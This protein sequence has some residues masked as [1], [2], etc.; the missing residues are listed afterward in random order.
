MQPQEET[1]RHTFQRRVTIT[2]L[3][4]MQQ[5]EGKGNNNNI[6]Q[7]MKNYLTILLVLIAIIMMASHPM[8]IHCLSSSSE[9]S[10]FMNS[11]NH[12]DVSMVE[13]SAQGNAALQSALD[14]LNYTSTFTYSGRITTLDLLNEVMKNSSLDRNTALDYINSYYVSI[15]LPV[16][17]QKLTNSNDLVERIE[18]LAVNRI[19]N[20]FY[21]MVNSYNVESYF[22]GKNTTVGKTVPL[23]TDLTSPYFPTAFDGKT[24]VMVF[25]PNGWANILKQSDSNAT[26]SRTILH[27]PQLKMFNPTTN[28]RNHFKIVNIMGKNASQVINVDSGKCLTFND[29]GYFNNL[30][31]DFQDCDSNN[32]NQLY[33]WTGTTLVPLFSRNGNQ[34]YALKRD[35]T[36]GTSFMEYSNDFKYT[37]ITLQ[38]VTPANYDVVRSQ[39]ISLTDSS[40]EQF[41]SDY[42]LV[43]DEKLDSTIKTF[44]SRSV[45]ENTDDNRYL[46]VIGTR[47]SIAPSSFSS[48][49]IYSLVLCCLVIIMH[50]V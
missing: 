40:I 10:S 42:S 29:F 48:S 36:F 4:L 37:T 19:R 20:S 21:L 41:Y 27:T 34:Y 32:S 50:F 49:F 44:V 12:G 24:F 18:V 43:L 3:V 17:F 11:D 16:R 15:R 38:L 45:Q 14:A 39:N 22:L 1:K 9:Y 8:M 35:F 26:S 2:D 28:S 46:K 13:Q 5:Q 23:F 25:K 47:W 33:V 30:I 31:A 7:V 6:Q